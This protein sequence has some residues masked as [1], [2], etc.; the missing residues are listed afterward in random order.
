MNVK[1]LS[2]ADRSC[3][4]SFAQWLSVARL[5]SA[6][7]PSFRIPLLGSSPAAT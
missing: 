1:H 7:V 4:K 5:V 6:T 3:L 2:M